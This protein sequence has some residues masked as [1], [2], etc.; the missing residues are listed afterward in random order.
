MSLPPTTLRSWILGRD[1]GTKQQTKRFQP[2]I[3]VAQRSP[4]ILS[5]RNLVE[6]HVL[7]AIRREHEI[8]LRLVRRAI[9]WLKQ[10]R[11]TRYP[12]SELELHTDD[13][14]LFIHEVGRLIN[15]SQDGQMEMIQ[16]VDQYLKRIERGPN[17]VPIRL[18]PFT[19]NRLDKDVR[20]VVVDPQVQFGRPCVTGTGIPTSVIAE[21]MKAGDTLAELAKDYGRDLREIE[22]AL[23]FEI[24]AA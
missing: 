17:G 10:R 5:F 8:P 3:E 18:Y 12:L 21:R 1:Y 6:A 16:V 23:R 11:G 9:R 22:E 24:R 4:A 20:A 14:D 2:V 13:K 19:S 15:V 7:S